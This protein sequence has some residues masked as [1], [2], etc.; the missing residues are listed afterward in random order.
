MNHHPRVKDLITLC[1]QLDYI[2]INFLEIKNR[3][4]DYSFIIFTRSH[5]MHK[6]FKAMIFGCFINLTTCDD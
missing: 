2:T 1:T 5:I 3:R 4:I 6:S